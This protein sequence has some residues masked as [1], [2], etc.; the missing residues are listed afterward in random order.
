MYVMLFIDFIFNQQCE[1]QFNAFKR[2]FFKTMTADVI[3]LFNE[4]ELDLLI[5]GSKILDFEDLEKATRY[6]DGYNKESGIVAWLWEV[7]H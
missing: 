7:I 3:D 4:E 2:G 6:V 5:S 1:T